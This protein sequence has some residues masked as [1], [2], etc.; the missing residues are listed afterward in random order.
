MLA[1][2]E[3]AESPLALEQLLK[4]FC[5]YFDRRT[6]TVVAGSQSCRIHRL[7]MRAN[8]RRRQ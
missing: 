2:R 8:V 6:K 5:D 1:K 3:S 7:G 4:T